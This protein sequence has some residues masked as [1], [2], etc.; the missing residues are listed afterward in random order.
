M[1]NYFLVLYNTFIKDERYMLIVNGLLF[2]LAVTILAALIGIILGV[3]LSLMTISD[4]S[5]I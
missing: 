1:D 5:P 2:T 3:V 4:F